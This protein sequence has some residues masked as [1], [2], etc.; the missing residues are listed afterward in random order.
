MRIRRQ[1]AD[2]VEVQMAPLIDVVFLLLIFFL[3]TMTI[4]KP[5]QPKEL[6]GEEPPRE[7]PLEL[8]HSAAAV[9]GP[10]PE[11]LLILSIDKDGNKYADLQPMTTAL[12]HQRVKDA[13]R[14]NP[15]Q[16]V[17]IDAD[18]ATRYEDVIEV[19]ELCQFEGLRDVGLHTAP[20]RAMPFTPPGSL[21]PGSLPPG[22]LRAAP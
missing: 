9:V 13:A 20:E 12:L 19:I 16:R 21:P 15:K 17:R 5:D 7:L 3:L 11:D 8:P 18:R 2:N 10:Q 14:K 4:K 6:P 1:E 22:G